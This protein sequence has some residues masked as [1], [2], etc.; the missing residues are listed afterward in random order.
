[1]ATLSAQARYLGHPGEAIDLA[2]A[3]Q[4]GATDDATV[5]AMCHVAEARAHAWRVRQ[6]EGQAARACLRTLSRADDELSRAGNDSAARAG[7]LNE[8]KLAAERR[9]PI[10]TSV[11]TPRGDGPARP[12]AGRSGHSTSGIR[13]MRGGVASP[14]SPSAGLICSRT[15]S[16]PPAPWVKRCW[17]RFGGCPR[18]IRR[19]ISA[20][21]RVS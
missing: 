12:G 5:S 10:S 9:T 19:D 2:R 1:M 8:G 6:G 20:S 17:T 14:S 3:G 18:P 7:F 16:P 13:G 4:R 21:S 11:S 15:T